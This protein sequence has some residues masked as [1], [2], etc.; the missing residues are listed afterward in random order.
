MPHIAGITNIIIILVCCI[1]ILFCFVPVVIAMELSNNN[2]EVA[3]G[4]DGKIE[5][6][7]APV[8]NTGKSDAS[9]RFRRKPSAVIAETS[10]LNN[11]SGS[12]NIKTVKPS[13]ALQDSKDS[14][15]AVPR[16]PK[17]S[18]LLVPRAMIIFSAAMYG[19]NYI[20]SKEITELQARPASA[21]SMPSSMVIAVRFLLGFLPYIP[22]L[23]I[24]SL[25]TPRQDMF[26]F[27]I[28]AYSLEL[29]VWCTLGF[30]AQAFMLQHESS[31]KVA[32]YASLATVLIPILEWLESL[33]VCTNLDS[34]EPRK[35][36]EL[37]Q[38]KHSRAWL[39]PL[40]VLFRGGLAVA[41]IMLIT[42]G[43]GGHEPATENVHVT[44]SVAATV[45]SEMIALASPLSFAVCLW[46]ME[47]IMHLFPASTTTITGLM[48]LWTAVLSLLWA[49]CIEASPTYIVSLLSS[50]FAQMRSSNDAGGLGR[51]VACYLYVG[52]C[53][54]ALPGMI[55]GYTLTRV[56]ASELT[57]LYSLEPLF[58]M[59][60]SAV[61]LGSTTLG[62]EVVA[63]GLLIVAA[64]LLTSL[65]K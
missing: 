64:C 12:N 26:S 59:L 44:K 16:S 53:G 3:V 61:L 1:W 47:H 23:G 36:A 4:C 38:T 22:V 30:L 57:L 41:G 55:E 10:S 14:T 40:M 33:F 32:L 29:G 37:Q 63:G 8:T 19:F 52:I 42:L 50:L 6:D 54:T 28:I 17:K 24:K 56:P 20:A 18:S 51:I 21:L 13:K 46:R 48:T 65:S 43:E 25:Q 45:L 60:F 15:A 5:D 7:Q 9:I 35:G 39:G 49:T 2:K 34:A 31:V 27:R 62:I 11:L 58:T